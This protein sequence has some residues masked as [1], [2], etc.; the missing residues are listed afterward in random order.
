MKRFSAFLLLT[1]SA[2][3]YSLPVQGQMT[4]GVKG[5]V[6]NSNGNTIAGASITARVNGKD[7][8][9]AHTD[10]KGEFVLQGLEPGVYSFVFD[11]NGYQSGVKSG[12]E[13]A[14]GKTRDLGDRLI[15]APDRGS[16]VIITGSVFDRGGH[17]LPDAEVRIDRLKADGSAKKL[18]TLY[19]NGVGEFAHRQAPGEQRFRVTASFGGKTASKEIQVDTAAIYR[20]AL[21]LDVDRPRQ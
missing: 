19:S 18:V 20:V 14:G 12:I 7:L 9:T 21:S 8:R 15:L 2:F 6:R 4:G 17:S 1:A 5:K 16:F 10:K 13:V 11:A 3:L